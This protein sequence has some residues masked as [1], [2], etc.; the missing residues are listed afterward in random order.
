MKSI[1]KELEL[2]PYRILGVVTFILTRIL[3][4]LSWSTL[5]D[6]EHNK[7]VHS[8]YVWL[9]IVPIS[10]KL[11]SKL[12]NTISFEISGKLVTLD[13]TMPFSWQALFFSACF[14]VVGNILVNFQI[15]EII[16]KYK[17]FND[18]STSGKTKEHL[19]ELQ[20]DRTDE[21]IKS[22]QS[23]KKLAG[24]SDST[25]SED[26]FKN[27]FNNVYSAIDY[28]NLWKR[29]FCSACYLAGL[30]FIIDI[31]HKNL[32]WVLS[33]MDLIEFKDKLFF[34]GVIDWVV[35]AF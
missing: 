12:E 23:L 3:F 31:A 13:L 32:I 9:F 28:E 11:F 14:F 29:G 27:K 25:D 6:I 2:V 34:S 18:F 16:K 24:I 22:L 4:T 7:V 20:G 17:N 35:K 21:S 5:R 8:T 26:D 19:K 15:P 30:L 10:A 33:S 1:K